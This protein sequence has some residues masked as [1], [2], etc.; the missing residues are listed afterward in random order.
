MSQHFNIKAWSPSHKFL[1]G[2]VLPV[3]PISTAYAVYMS[4]WISSLLT[5]TRQ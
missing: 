3:S 2:A 1:E 5:A 4:E